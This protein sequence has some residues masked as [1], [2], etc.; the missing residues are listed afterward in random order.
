MRWSWAQQYT[1]GRQGA[2]YYTINTWANVKDIPCPYDKHCT[3][4]SAS[5]N[6][7]DL[8]LHKENKTTAKT[9]IIAYLTYNICRVAHDLLYCV[10]SHPRQLC[11]APRWSSRHLAVASLKTWQTHRWW[12]HWS[13]AQRP[14]HLGTLTAKWRTQYFIFWK[15]KKKQV[16]KFSLE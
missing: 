8:T 10:S 7:C 16:Y 2:L 3:I 4:L 15:T 5:Y 1:A 13:S 12:S 11:P 14:R 9:L 6:F